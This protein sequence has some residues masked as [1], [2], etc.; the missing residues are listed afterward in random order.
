MLTRRWSSKAIWMRSGCSGGSICWV[1]LVSGRFPLS[2][3]IIP[4]AKEHFLTPSPRRDAHLFG[5]LG[6]TLIIHWRQGFVTSSAIGMTL[7]GIFSSRSSP[8]I[9]RDSS[10]RR[11]ASAYL[12]D[13][14]K[15]LPMRS[16]YSWLSVSFQQVS[17]TCSM[18]SHASGSSS[19]LRSRSASDA[20]HRSGPHSSFG[21]SMAAAHSVLG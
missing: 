6:F 18:S 7:I 12:G 5:G 8:L 15:F 13:F 21:V 4:D 3:T 16:A 2:K 1:L 10:S 19:S 17:S 11:A 14:S 9:F 20:V